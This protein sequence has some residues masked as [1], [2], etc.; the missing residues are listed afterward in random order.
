MQIPIGVSIRT[1]ALSGVVADI[2]VTPQNLWADG[3]A[4]SD[5]GAVHNVTTNNN[6]PVF[7]VTETITCVPEKSVES[8]K[9][10]SRDTLVE[11]A[12]QLRKP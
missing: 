7:H 1:D 8:H 9:K 12:R 6:Q 3:M 4:G 11:I 2:P 10:I 5:T